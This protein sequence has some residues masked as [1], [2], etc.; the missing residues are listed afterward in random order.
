VKDEKDKKEK[1]KKEKAAPA[2]GAPAP[3]P[4]P[5]PAATPQDAVVGSAVVV[6]VAEGA[7][8]VR[9]PGAAVSSPLGAG[10]AVPVGSVVDAREGTV[11]LS[12]Q[13]PGRGTQDALL[14]GA[15]FEVRQAKADGMTDLVLR[16]GDF[17]GCR[18][19]GT[20]TAHAAARAK[21]PRR[22]LWAKDDS[23]R[24]RTHGRNSVATVRGTEWTTT[25][26]CEGTRTTVRRGAVL[27]RDKATG[28]SVLVR[29]GHS[30]LAP[31]RR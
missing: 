4:A 13:V 28:R 31:A 22:S 6:G 18:R 21:T 9:A 26:T 12:A 20:T 7:A 16:G 8:T 19:A 5:G 30:H 10:A 24:F 17:R 1:G 27:V 15:R 11:R 2:P 29:A 25:D 3:D 14:R 23:G